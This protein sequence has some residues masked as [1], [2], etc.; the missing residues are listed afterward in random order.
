MSKMQSFYEINLF[1]LLRSVHTQFLNKFI[2]SFKP[3]DEP[4]DTLQKSI[5]KLSSVYFLLLFSYLFKLKFYQTG[6]HAADFLAPEYKTE[7]KL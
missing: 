5:N 6:G 4:R 1:F 2:A 3:T 7:N